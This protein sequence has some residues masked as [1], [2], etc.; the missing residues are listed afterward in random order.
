MFV[1]GFTDTKLCDYCSNKHLYNW[2]LG[3]SLD[4]NMEVAITHQEAEQSEPKFFCMRKF[5]ADIRE[6]DITKCYPYHGEVRVDMLPPLH[7]PKFKFWAFESFK[8]N[9]DIDREDEIPKQSH[10]NNSGINVHMLTDGDASTGLSVPQHTSQEVN[11]ALADT[12]GGNEVASH[13][14]LCIDMQENEAEKEDAL[15]RDEDVVAIKNNPS[16]GHEDDVAQDDNRD[17]NGAGDNAKEMSLTGAT[18]E[19]GKTNSFGTFLISM[20]TQRKRKRSMGSKNKNSHNKKPYS[21]RKSLTKKKQIRR[22]GSNSGASETVDVTDNK[23]EDVGTTTISGIEPPTV[24]SNKTDSENSEVENV[25]AHHGN[26]GET[27]RRMQKIRTRTMKYL[28]EKI[29]LNKIEP[30]IDP[31]EPAIDQIEHVTDQIEPAIDQIAPV[32]DQTKPAVVQIERAID[33]IEPVTDQIAP[34]IN[35][36]E[37]AIDQIEPDIDLSKIRPYIDLNLSPTHQG[38]GIQYE[39]DEELQFNLQK[40]VCKEVEE[41]AAGNHRA[42]DKKVEEARAGNQHAADAKDQRLTS[43]KRKGKTLHY[44]DEEQSLKTS[45]GDNL[46]G[47]QLNNE[48]VRGQGTGAGSF[49]PNSRKDASTRRSLQSEIEAH[50]GEQRN[51]A[52]TIQTKDKTVNSQ[53]IANRSPLIPSRK[54]SMPQVV[55]GSSSLGYQ[56]EDPTTPRKAKIQKEQFDQS[57]RTKTSERAG[58]DEIPMEI[59]EMM[60]K[61]QHERFLGASENTNVLPGETTNELIGR[62]SMD[63]TEVLGSEIPRFLQEKKSQKQITQSRNAGNSSSGAKRVGSTRQTDPSGY[64][65]QSRHNSIP[66]LPEQSHTSTRF[67]TFPQN[68]EKPTRTEFL[69]RNS[70]INYLNTMLS[71]NHDQASITAQ[72]LA[73]YRRKFDNQNPT[74]FINREEPSSGAQFLT[75]T[76]SRHCGDQITALSKNQEKPLNGAQVLK[77]SC[78][79]LCHNQTST[80]VG[81]C[82]KPPTRSQFLF[83]SSSKNSVNQNTQWDGRLEGQRYSH[84]GFQ[85]SG[86]YQTSQ[87]TSWQNSLRNNRLALPPMMPNRF[88]SGISNAQKFAVE[89]KTANKQ[90]PSLELFPNENMNG[91]QSLTYRDPFA[92]L[93]EKK[94]NFELETSKGIKP[95]YPFAQ[96]ERGVQL[97]KQPMQPVNFFNNETIPATHLLRLMDARVRPSS[98]PVNMEENQ[99]YNQQ[100]FL[101]H[102]GH[103]Q[104][105]LSRYGHPKRNEGL[106]LPPSS[107]SFDKI[108]PP[109]KFSGNFVSVPEVNTASSSIQKKDTVPEVPVSRGDSPAILMPTLPTG[110]AKGKG[111]IKEAPT[112]SKSSTS[113]RYASGKGTAG[114]NE[115]I[116]ICHL[117]KGLVFTPEPVSLSAHST[118]TKD[119]TKPVELEAKKSGTVSPQKIRKKEFCMINRNPADFT[120]PEEIGSQHVVGHGGPKLKENVLSEERTCQIEPVGNKRKKRVKHAAIKG[121]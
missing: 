60:A 73:D 9:A 78:S 87:T 81:T 90:S 92:N 44:E 97:G 79:R 26:E 25:A 67:N 47:V 59:V 108:P 37:P 39:D 16:E 20:E 30:V 46:R 6:K 82:N 98:S 50:N 117:Q 121:M 7:V 99:K 116:S 49:S 13:K 1:L 84:S 105:D 100:H 42:A 17:G 54:R 104:Q 64:N 53:L 83:D 10:P 88:P 72:L 106:M 45:Q 71:K 74:N 95:Q 102:G 41:A 96:N 28:Y 21:G 80:F 24:E 62:T 70:S 22:N 15:H 112:Q 57:P 34:A 69:G 110:Q 38:M 89:S 55:N 4:L 19:A 14:L 36:I 119:S 29:D 120:L 12:T 8:K 40:N 111:K 52:K 75:G 32:T 113:S 65:F 66:S 5:V 11:I 107:K 109:G 23:N 58:S 101:T 114:K 93:L 33:Q 3:L 85:T 61:H 35:Q 94:T 51:G 91:D 77:G 86:V 76:S 27:P 2:N 48:N 115:T 63:E 118:A 56:P 43:R 31:T 68:Q 18:H 103:Q